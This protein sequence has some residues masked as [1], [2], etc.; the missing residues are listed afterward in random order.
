MRKSTRSQLA[1]F[2][3]ASFIVGALVLYAF[4]PKQ[5]RAIEGDVIFGNTSSQLGGETCGPNSFVQIGPTPGQLKCADFQA[6]FATNAPEFT[7][8]NLTGNVGIGS[9]FSGTAFPD[10]GLVSYWKM[11]EVSGNVT[12]FKGVSPLTN[13]STTSIAGKIGNGRNFSGATQYLT[14]ANNNAYNNTAAFSVSAWVKLDELTARMIVGNTVDNFELQTTGGVLLF[15]VRNAGGWGTPTQSA[16][17]AIATGT[18]YHVVGTF[19]GTNIKVYR[20]GVQ[21]GTNVAR[22]APLVT[23]DY[24]IRVGTYGAAPG[25]FM[26]GVIDEVGIW[27]RAITATEVASL[28]NSGNGIVPGQYSAG[29]AIPQKLSVDREARIQNKLYLGTSNLY[30]YRDPAATD[31]YIQQYSADAVATGTRY[32]FTNGTRK[33]DVYGDPTHYGLLSSAGAWAL[34][35]PI[36]GN[37]IEAPVKAGAVRV[38]DSNNNAYYLDP[39]STSE[40]NIMNATE[41]CLNGDCRRVWIGPT[42][43][44]TPTHSPTPTNTPTHTPTPVY[45]YS[46]GYYYGQGYYYSQGSYCV[47]QS[48]GH[49]GSCGDGVCQPGEVCCADCAAWTCPPC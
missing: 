4:S 18:W 37:T 8:L 26:D 27:N 2:V 1:I 12:D 42:N 19:D 31:A 34:K 36:T 39:A 44:P 35:V 29:S 23:G 40:L 38:V 10:A 49:Y 48:A 25:W 32:N 47:G 28:Y 46:Q 6:A 43:T 33:G 45:S 15:Y 20:N 14:S 16:A 5:S 3:F 7:N 11:Q 21:V 22:A 13:A 24:S 17:A 9:S 30:L 41:V